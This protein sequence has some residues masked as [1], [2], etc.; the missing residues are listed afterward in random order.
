MTTD[1]F[2]STKPPRAKPRVMA[3]IIDA[4]CSC[5]SNLARFR[6]RRCGWE[7]EWLFVASI[8]G[9][10]RGTPCE[11]CNPSDAKEPTNA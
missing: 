4:G 8:T 6:C 11:K 3:H 7:S 10:K 1:L 5:E 2:P 9:G